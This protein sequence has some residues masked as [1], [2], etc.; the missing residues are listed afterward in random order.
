MTL[1][2]IISVVSLLGI[3]GLLGAYFRVLWERNNA[4]LK[5]DYKKVRYKCIIILALAYLDLP[6]FCSKVD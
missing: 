1:E 3:G 4:I 2:N 5:Q 6:L